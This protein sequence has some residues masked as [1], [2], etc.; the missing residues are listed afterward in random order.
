[1]RR[2]IR[3]RTLRH[4]THRVALTDVG[5][6]TA[7]HVVAVGGAL[8]GAVDSPLR[9]D[10]TTPGHTWANQPHDTWLPL[11]VRWAMRLIRPYTPTARHRPTA[12]H[13]AHR[14]TRTDVGEP[15]AQYV[16]AVGGA[17][18]D[19]VD[20]PLRPGRTLPDP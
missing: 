14:A 9:P 17:L 13:P 18:G 10:R 2:R 8:A 12:G 16:V 5:E 7:Q 11:A 19:A 1:V 6:P 3:V 20:S 15:T 4:P